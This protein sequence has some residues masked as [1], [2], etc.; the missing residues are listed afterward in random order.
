MR[1]GERED[2]SLPK[3]DVGDNAYGQAENRQAD[4]DVGDKGEDEFFDGGK[5]VTHGFCFGQLDG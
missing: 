2:G 4:A 5:G 1:E 3:E